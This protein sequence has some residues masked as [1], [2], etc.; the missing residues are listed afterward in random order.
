MTGMQ[1]ARLLSHELRRRHGKHLRLTKPACS[2]A[3]T[4]NTRAV[5]SVAALKAVCSDPKEHN[6]SAYCCVVE[7]AIKSI[8]CARVESYQLM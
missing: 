7:G 3:S 8:T 6:V 1:L 2:L 5:G 4:K